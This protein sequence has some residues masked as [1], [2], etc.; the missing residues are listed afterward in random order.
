MTICHNE[1]K[2]ETLYVKSEIDGPNLH[3]SESIN[4]PSF[5]EGEFFTEIDANGCYTPVG[6]IA[7]VAELVIIIITLMDCLSDYK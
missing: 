3:L 7:T 4:R 1:A 6:Q 5:K 2:D